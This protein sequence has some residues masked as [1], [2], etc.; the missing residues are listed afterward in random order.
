MKILPSLLTL[1]LHIPFTSLRYFG[2]IRFLMSIAIRKIK[3]NKLT[4][5]GLNMKR[6]VLGSSQ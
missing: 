2:V 3:I 4:C 5:A 1:I 6:F